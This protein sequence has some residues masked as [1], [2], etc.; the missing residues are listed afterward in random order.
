MEAKKIINISQ[1]ENVIKYYVLMAKWLYELG[2]FARTK[3]LQM[4]LEKQNTSRPHSEYQRLL[5]KYYNGSEEELKNAVFIKSENSQKILKELLSLSR[6]IGIEQYYD[7]INPRTG[8]REL[9]MGQDDGLIVQ[10]FCTIYS[11]TTY[12]SRLRRKNTK[13][14][15]KNILID[16]ANIKEDKI[17][18]INREYVDSFFTDDRVKELSKEIYLGLTGGVESSIKSIIAAD[19]V[20]PFII[21]AKTL[22]SLE[23][24]FQH[25]IRAMKVS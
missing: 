25:L 18:S 1:I 14:I 3:Y 16:F 11:K 23:N 22:Y 5:E 7:K 12:G 24:N 17:S 10:N 2:D 13:D 20:L 15:V 6:Q 19:K 9:I 8:K 4:D 21:R